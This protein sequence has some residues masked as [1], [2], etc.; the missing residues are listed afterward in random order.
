MHTVRPNKP[1]LLST[2]FVQMC[3]FIFPSL[4][5]LSSG[6][7]VVAVDVVVVVNWR[8]QPN[9]APCTCHF[10]FVK[11]EWNEMK[12]KRKR[13]WA[14]IAMKYAIDCHCVAGIR[15]RL[16]TSS[17]SSFC[18]G[19]SVR[20]IIA[21]FDDVHATAAE[22]VI[23]TGAESQTTITVKLCCWRFWSR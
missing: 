8:P 12:R 11:L 16:R 17:I 3:K 22:C 4:S 6:P 18:I 23:Y 15:M 13:N 21:G 7:F 14:S 20:K 1:C 19:K 5:S 10:H 2:G 9:T